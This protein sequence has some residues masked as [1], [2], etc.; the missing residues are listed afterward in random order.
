M[1]RIKLRDLL[2][3]TQARLAIIL[4]LATAQDEPSTAS[5]NLRHWLA[6][7]GDLTERLKMARKALLESERLDD[8]VRSLL[9]DDQAMI[10]VVEQESILREIGDPVPAQRRHSVQRS[11]YTHVLERFHADPVK[12]PHLKHGLPFLVNVVCPPFP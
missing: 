12:V 7:F 8:A 6:E 2:D 11:D 5:L 4:G 1:D 3:A 10:T 9:D